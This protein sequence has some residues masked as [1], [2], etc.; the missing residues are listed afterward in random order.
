MQSMSEMVLGSCVMASK[1]MMR[2]HADGTGRGD[3]AAAVMPGD[4][5]V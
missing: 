1:L 3:S 4:F 2:Q 5:I